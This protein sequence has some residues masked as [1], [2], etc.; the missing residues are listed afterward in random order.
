MNEF[1]LI[2]AG[3]RDFDDYELLVRVMYSMQDT[4][5]ADKEVS[6]VS[7]MAKGA[8]SLGYM[9]AHKHDVKVYEFNANWNQ[10]GKSAGYKRN[11]EM[12]KFAD[13]LL[14]FYSGS[15]GTGHMIKYMHSL[16]KPVTVIPYNRYIYE[17]I[18]S[19]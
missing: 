17:G 19:I 16:N 10:Y 1:K 2:I 7:G 12:G 4:D 9:F 3:G 13:G 6:I 14:A 15:K 18:E 5:F 11:T 8:D